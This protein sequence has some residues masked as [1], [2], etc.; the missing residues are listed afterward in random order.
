MSKTRISPDSANWLLSASDPFHDFEHP[1]EGAPDEA[2]S[3]SYTRKFVQTQTVSASADDDQITIFFTGCHGGN[4]VTFQSWGVDYIPDDIVNGAGGPLAPIT[5]VR[6]AAGALAPSLNSAIMG[7]T[8]I[9]GRMYTRQVNDIPSRLVSIGLEVTDVTAQLYKKG[10][11]FVAHANGEVEDGTYPVYDM[12]SAPFTVPFFRKPILPYTQSQAMAIPG[13]Y[14][15]ALAKGCYVVG[16]LNK[17]QPPRRGTVTYTNGSTFGSYLQRPL[18]QET[19]TPSGPAVATL[20]PVCPSLTVAT[21]DEIS[22]VPT[23]HDSG[24]VPFSVIMNG[25]AVETTLQI[26]VKCTVEYFPQSTHPFECGLATYS[27]SFEPEAFRIYHEIMRQIPAA[28]PVGFNGAGDYWRMVQA[29]AKKVAFGI[30]RYGPALADSLS[31]FGSMSGQPEAIALGRMVGMATNA[32][33]KVT[34]QRATGKKK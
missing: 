17:I 29:A 27:P 11:L 4:D 13:S 14:Q 23:W 32:V 33:A 21:F 16:R 20:Q 19:S 10:T 26:T 12:N 6:R 22:A 24:F 3:K 8:T 15:G 1:I 5:I 7:T 25:M 9:L 31:L 2:I 30:A 18:I 34:K 28:V